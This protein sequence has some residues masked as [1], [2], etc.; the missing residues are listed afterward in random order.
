MTSQMTH[1]KTDDVACARFDERLMAYLE[2]ELDASDREWMDQH[3]S[4]CARCQAIVADVETLSRSAA[5]LPNLSPSRDLWDGI[6]A[7]LE[8]PVVPLH[9]RNAFASHDVSLSSSQ[10]SAAQ[11]GAVRKERSVSVR[12]FAIAATLLITVSSAVTWQLARS[13]NAAPTVATNT[14]TNS[15]TLSDTSANSALIVPVANA[16]VVYQQQIDALRTIVNARFDELDST[17]VSVLRRNLDIID[18]AIDDSRKALEKDPNSRIL[19]TKLDRALETKLS[20]MRRVA[21]L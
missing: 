15:D 17:T 18:K 14:N 3:Q 6:A 13:R 11:S 7:H 16:D 5:T 20:L 10:S 21:L 19:S 12:L 4:A 9:G 8:A 2:H 1:P